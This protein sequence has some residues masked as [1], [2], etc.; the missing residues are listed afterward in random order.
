M[1]LLS[2]HCARLSAR[3]PHELSKSVER[4]SHKAVGWRKVPDHPGS[5]QLPTGTDERQCGA[6]LSVPGSGR[7]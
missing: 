3:A 1:Q 2:L 5:R 7:S 6:E 4:T